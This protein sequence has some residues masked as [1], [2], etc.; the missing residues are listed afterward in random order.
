MS[1]ISETPQAIHQPSL[2]Y[3]LTIAAGVVALLSFFMIHIGMA[4]HMPIIFAIAALLGYG[5]S[6]K[7]PYVAMQ[8]GM[9][10]SVHVSMGAIYLLLFI[11][12]L[13]AA[14]LMCG[15]IPSLIY[16]GFYIISPKYFYLSSFLLTSLIGIAI[17]SSLTTCATLGIALIGM[18]SAFNVSLPIT[19]GAIVSGAFFGDKMSPFSDT[20]NIAASIVGVDL[21]EHI[22]NMTYTTIP[23]FIIASAFYAFLSF[24]TQEVRLQDVETFR[25]HLLATNLVHPEA[26]L[27]F[28]LL[29]TLAVL[30]IKAVP[31]IILTTILAIVLTYMHRQPSLAELGRFLFAGF[32]PQ[33]SDPAIQSL[34]KRGGLQ[35]MFFTI[36]IVILAISMGG[37]LFTLGIIPTL[38]AAIARFLSKAGHATSCVA[39]TSVGV[40]LMIGEQYLSILL[41]GETFKPIYDRLKLH[42]KNLSRTLEDAGTVIN[43]LVPWSVC[44]VFIAEQLNVP[45]RAYLPYAIFCYSCLFLTLI[46]GWSGIT[47]SHRDDTKRDEGQSA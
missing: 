42:R 38:L 23:A 25:Q 2:P 31:S 28:I 9:S 30:K 39:A 45:V 32:D 14:L 8:K 20:T 5:L 13:I 16:Y 22:R 18:A 6:Q 19:A 26:L 17:G 1:E 34:L 12:I 33:S 24:G 44:G 40:N 43:P 41:A 11:G 29:I 10:D 36:T 27:A 35:S 47:I 37:L 7:I 4:P 15:A 21:F 46:F 3:A